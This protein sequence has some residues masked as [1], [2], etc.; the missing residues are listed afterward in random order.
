MKIYLLLAMQTLLETPL[1]SVDV[2]DK[3]QDQHASSASDP[4]R[5]PKRRKKTRG[6]KGEAVRR[7]LATQMT[8]QWRVLDFPKGLFV[9]WNNQGHQG[10]FFSGGGAPESVI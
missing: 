3:D 5:S 7:T 1:G 8:P 4:E 9:V 6:K 10:V 2:G